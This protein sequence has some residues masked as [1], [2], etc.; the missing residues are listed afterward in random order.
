M[1]DQPQSMPSS[2]LPT[3]ESVEFS[4]EALGIT[5]KTDEKT[6]IE[7]DEIQEEAV[8]AAQASKKFALR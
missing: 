8:R 5:L 1:P 7:I 6:L 2:L 3:S 4:A